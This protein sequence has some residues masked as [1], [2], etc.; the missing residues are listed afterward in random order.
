VRSLLDVSVLIPLLQKNHIYFD[1]AHQWWSANRTE[2]WASCPLTQN[3][4]LRI[5]PQLRLS[6]PMVVS[7]ALDLLFDLIAATD[8]AF[9]PDDVSLLDERL[10][11]RNHVL[12]P[13]QLTDIY[14]LALAVKHG[15]RLVTFD[16]A[17]PVGA[18][19]GAQADHLVVI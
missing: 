13:K 5:V 16:R 1:R 15:G 17:I 4:F 2:G 19:R 18:V 10:I 8:H 6:G 14:L 12:G 9:W 3:G 7:D 11:D